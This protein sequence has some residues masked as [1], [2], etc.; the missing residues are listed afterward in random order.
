MT[1][2]KLQTNK[3][4]DNKERVERVLDLMINH[5]RI[6]DSP[7]GAMRIGKI[8]NIKHN[9]RLKDDA[10]LSHKKQ[11]PLNPIIRKQVEDQLKK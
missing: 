9:I 8:K 3:L 5:W 10:I 7:N 11:R 2:L 1:K 6:L 4:L